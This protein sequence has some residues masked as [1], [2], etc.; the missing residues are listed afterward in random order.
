MMRTVDEI[1]KDIAKI[2]ER[3]EYIGELES[4]MAARQESLEKELKE[5]YA[6]NNPFTM[7]DRYGEKSDELDNIWFVNDLGF[8]DC[9]DVDHTVICE[10]T[11][12]WFQK[13]QH[14]K[15]VNNNTA[16]VYASKETADFALKNIRLMNVMLYFKDKYDIK[17]PLK[18]DSY[19][20]RYSTTKFEYYF[21]SSSDYYSD[22]HVS[23]D[24]DPFIIWFHSV[25]A[26]ERCVD[27]IN[28]HKGLFS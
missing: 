5:A 18:I 23:G 13:Y 10:A 4:K 20:I 19:T 3:L 25:Q 15:T 28:S 2:N 14:L 9:L 12:E 7:T 17:N 11:D 1:K 8:I 21:L 24:R 6:E 22:K 26:V 16:G 27:Y